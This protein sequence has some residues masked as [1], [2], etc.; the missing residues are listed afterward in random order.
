MS[1]VC[2][3]VRWVKIEKAIS[4]V[5]ACDDSY[6]IAALNLDTSEPFGILSGKFHPL[7]V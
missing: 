6:R 7:V 2:T 1:L 5:P 4:Y 3:N